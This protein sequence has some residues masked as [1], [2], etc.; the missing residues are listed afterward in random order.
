MAV[1]GGSGGGHFNTGRYIKYAENNTRGNTKYGP[2]HSKLLVSVAQ[3]MGLD[4]NS[5]GMASG[6]VGGAAADLAGPLP[7][8]KA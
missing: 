6:S 1:I 4:R 3:A 7:M 2:A 8:L 5:I